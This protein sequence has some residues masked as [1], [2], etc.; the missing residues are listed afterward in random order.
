MPIAVE[1]PDQPE[2]GRLTEEL[3]AHQKP[4]Y[5]PESH[6]GIDIASLSQ[7]NVVFAVTRSSDGRAI[8]CGAVVLGNEYA[9][10]KRMYVP[11]GNRG[12]SIG[13]ALLSFL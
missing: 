5:P 3:D 6:H 12:Q 2:V 11:P 13:K 8:G 4:L 7:P 1:H 9:E 10:L